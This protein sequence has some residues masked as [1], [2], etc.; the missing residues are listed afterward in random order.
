MR[1][2]SPTQRDDKG[3]R[4]EFRIPFS[5]LRFEPGKSDTFGTRRPRPG[6][7]VTS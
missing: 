3:W 7:D 4:A 2:A 1:H 5:Q 6:N